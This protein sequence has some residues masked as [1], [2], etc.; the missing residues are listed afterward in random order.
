MTQLWKNV[1]EKSTLRDCHKNR[2]GDGNCMEVILR[3]F[4]AIRW[5]GG[6]EENG[7]QYAL[8]NVQKNWGK[9]KTLLIK[10]R[11]GRYTKFWELNQ[12]E[13]MDRKVTTT[14]P[15]QYAQDGKEGR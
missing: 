11:K 9:A 1:R 7:A 15:R 2:R 3:W 12:A 4:T 6:V 5:L 10:R 14:V 8:Q 13:R